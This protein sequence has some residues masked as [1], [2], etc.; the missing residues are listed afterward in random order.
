MAEMRVDKTKL[1]VE[2][3]KIV[4]KREMEEIFDPEEYLRKVSK[5]EGEL[6]QAKA[7]VEF[8]ERVVKEWCAK[9]EEAMVLWEE[10]MKKGDEEAKAAEEKA[11]EDSN[12]DAS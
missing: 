10:A 7:M 12:T 4:I 9:K 5:E 11:N 1:S 8:K 6:E 3:G 2:D